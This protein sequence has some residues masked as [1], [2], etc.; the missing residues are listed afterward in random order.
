MI[1]AMLGRIRVLLVEDHALVREALFMRLSAESD[2]EIVAQASGLAEAEAALARLAPD[3]ILLDFVLG[4]GDP[5][6]IIPSWKARF[7]SARVVMLTASHNGEIARRA[8]QAGAVGFVCKTDSFEELL[9]VIRKAARGRVA[10]TP[11]VQEMLGSG[12]E[13]GLSD[14]EL[15]ALRLIAAGKATREIAAILGISVKTAER[16]REN[17]KS[18]LRAETSAALMREAVLRFPD[19]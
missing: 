5:L 12:R 2:V 18:K 11:T 10:T 9:G 15:Q 16:H 14:R 1:P 4:D 8:L 3:V 6:H 13:C 17:I 19:P 7:R